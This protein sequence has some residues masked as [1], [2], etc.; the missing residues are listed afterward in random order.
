[1]YLVR[2]TMVPNSVIEFKAN[3]MLVTASMLDPRAIIALLIAD[4]CLFFSGVFILY[5]KDNSF[6]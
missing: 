1:M 2:L 6:R 5:H 4:D 3:D